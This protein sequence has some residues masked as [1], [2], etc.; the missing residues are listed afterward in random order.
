MDWGRVYCPICKRWV[1]TA[2][3]NIDVDEDGVVHRICT[4]CIE[5]TVEKYNFVYDPKPHQLK[6]LIENK[7]CVYCG[8]YDTK[9]VEGNHWKCNDCEEDFYV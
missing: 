7:E 2:M 3:M 1:P 4:P 5:G 9:Q 8:S 6:H